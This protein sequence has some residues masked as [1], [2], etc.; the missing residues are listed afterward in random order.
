MIARYRRSWVGPFWIMLSTAVFIGALSVVYGTL[1]RMDIRE[2]VP[3]VAVGVVA[4]GFISA[5]AN[6]SLTTFVEAEAYIRQ[7]RV[8]LFVTRW[9]LSGSTR[10]LAFAHQFVVVKVWACAFLQFLF[11]HAAAR[12]RWNVSIFVA[13]DV[14]HT[15]TRPFG[16][17]FS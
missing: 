12:N 1:F 9:R 3:Y 15:F 11:G 10:V 14:G 17:A 16:H 4:W 5:V 2:Y 8:N 7:I 13:G 6:E